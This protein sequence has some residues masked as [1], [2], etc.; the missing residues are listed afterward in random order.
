M[1]CVICACVDGGK[2]NS[3]SV[4]LLCLEFVYIYEFLLTQITME[5]VSFNLVHGMLVFNMLFL[6]GVCL[7]ML[8]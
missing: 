1:V 6:N 2:N 8:G 7:P 5:D 3:A 4:P